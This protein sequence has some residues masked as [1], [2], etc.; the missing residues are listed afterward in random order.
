MTVTALIITGTS[1]V[2]VRRIEPTLDALQELV[3]GDIEAVTLD[4]ET[5]LYIDDEG[6]FRE[7]PVVNQVATALVERFHPG[8]SR[9]DVIMGTAVVLGGTDDGEEADVPASIRAM[10]GLADA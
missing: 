4:K 9:R 8:F 5:H 2:E 3:G 6:K 7:N 10:F 1:P